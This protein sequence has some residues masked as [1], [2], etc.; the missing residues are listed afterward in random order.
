MIFLTSRVRM[1]P[2]SVSGD[3]GLRLQ[4]R[5]SFSPSL[6]TGTGEGE[7]WPCNAAARPDQKDVG[8]SWCH[9]SNNCFQQK[10]QFPIPALTKWRVEQAPGQQAIPRN[11][12]LFM[13]NLDTL[14]A[15]G[16]SSS[17]HGCKVTYGC[18]LPTWHV[19]HQAKLIFDCHV[20]CGENHGST[21]PN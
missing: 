14:H 18:W 2:A 17:L 20:T 3:R 11:N 4:R 19:C 9:Y 10:A 7:T 12:F 13:P 5:N 6:G 1:T 16:N 21:G 15:C 8:S